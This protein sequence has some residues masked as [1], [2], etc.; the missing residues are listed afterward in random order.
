MGQTRFATTKHNRIENNGLTQVAIYRLSKRSH[1]TMA[2]RLTSRAFAL[3]LTT[4]Q[5]A[6]A[7][8][9]TSKSLT[10]FGGPVI[11]NPSVITLFYGN[12][13]KKSKINEFYK[14]LVKSPVMDV[15]SHDYSTPQYAIG[16]GSFNGS[17]NIPTSETRVLSDAN[18][19]QPMLL[20]LVQSGKIK[21]TN[22][23]YLALHLGPG[24]SAV[25]G[26]TETCVNVCAY[27]GA[28]DV[29]GV[30]GNPVVPYLYYGVIPTFEGAC[31]SGCGDSDTFSNTCAVASHEFVESVTNPAGSKAMFY[32]HPL[33]WYDSVDASEIGDLCNLQQGRL[34]D[35]SNTWTIQKVWSNSYQGCVSKLP[36]LKGESS[37]N[38]TSKLGKKT[39]NSKKSH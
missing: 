20:Q 25:N 38:K 28:V 21:P 30:L 5:V 32:S 31:L 10:Y 15:V 2:M 17:L 9:V 23:T 12:V 39:K 3:L 26:Q 37:F 35:E 16:Y 1:E 11:Q 29:V 7:L 22:N 27:H 13:D 14:F 34:S 19:I 8:P 6:Q 36:T 33:G 4:S 18:D 24:I